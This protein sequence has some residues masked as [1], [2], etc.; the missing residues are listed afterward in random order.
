MVKRAVITNSCQWRRRRNMPESS[1]RPMWPINGDFLPFVITE[2]S[3]SGALAVQVDDCNTLTLDDI[4]HSPLH[5]PTPWPAH[6]LS[7]V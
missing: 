2:A 1:E 5:N 4:P 3:L 6:A 7:P